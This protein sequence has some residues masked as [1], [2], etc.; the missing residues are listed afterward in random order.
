MSVRRQT[1]GAAAVVAAWN[2][3]NS[4]CKVRLEKLIAHRKTIQVEFKK[5]TLE[6]QE[7]ANAITQAAKMDGAVLID[8][9]SGEVCALAVILD[10]LSCVEGSPSRGARFNSLKNFTAS[11]SRQGIVSFVFSS[12]GGMDI[13]SGKTIQADGPLPPE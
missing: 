5:L 4:R 13:F 3:P 2:D 9:Q 11:L 7:L 10:G 12:D 1:H 6:S 8:A